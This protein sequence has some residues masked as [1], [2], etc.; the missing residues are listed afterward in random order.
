MGQASCSFA[1]IVRRSSQTIA[2]TKFMAFGDSIT[3][4]KVSL[5]PLISLAGPDTYPFKLEQMLQQ[6]YPTQ[7]VEVMNRGLSGERYSVA[8]HDAFRECWTRTNPRSC[9][10]LKGSMPSG[11]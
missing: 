5:V 7:T 8:V 9:C 6:R 11:C 4:G 1:V 10:F 3:D 2:K